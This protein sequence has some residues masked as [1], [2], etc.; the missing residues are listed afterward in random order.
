MSVCDRVRG[1]Q[2][3]TELPQP[4]HYQAGHPTAHD[5]AIWHTCQINE[6]LDAGASDAWP[7]LRTSF[8]PVHAP[9]EHVFANGPFSLY[10]F[11]ADGDGSY[12][13][14]GGFFFA[15]GG[16]GLALTAG[17]A[18]G[19]AIG[20]SRRRRA[21]IR[22]AQPS[23]REIDRG[24]VW[25]TDHGFSFLTATGQFFS[26]GF[27]AISAA[28]LVGPAALWFSGE[29]VNGP[30]SWILATDWAELVFTFWCRVRHPH[31]EQFVNGAW[32]PPGWRDRVAA[33]DVPLPAHLVSGS[34]LR[35][36]LG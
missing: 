27:G 8:A 24:Q 3:T 23:W 4:P 15:T 17:L 9:D 1:D 13:H 14:D 20:N 22:A 33:M 7:A 28:H 19:R 11:G 35:E 36:I 30:V 5:V 6:L 26:W 31:H 18:A 2:M 21:A 10:D 34:E 29:S 32:V 12:A 16:V 25:V